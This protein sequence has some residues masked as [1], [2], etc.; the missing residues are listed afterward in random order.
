MKTI[1]K[2]TMDLA[3]MWSLCSD[4]NDGVRALFGGSVL[5]ADNRTVEAVAVLNV[6]VIRIRAANPP[7][8][9]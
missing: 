3:H 7:K 8:A 9:S 2:E 6:E 1:D 4:A 5:S